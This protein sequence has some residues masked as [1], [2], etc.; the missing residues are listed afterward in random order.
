MGSAWGGTSVRQVGQS[1]NRDTGTRVPSA[2]R[3]P[4]VNGGSRRVGFTKLQV[5][6][7]E[8]ASHAH[9]HLLLGLSSPQRSQQPPPGVPSSGLTPSSKQ[10]GCFPRTSQVTS[11]HRLQ[12]RQR[13]HVAL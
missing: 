5:L 13:V 6:G 2:A 11:A 8:T 7:H 10:P 4:L 12:A 1:Q 9:C 3:Y